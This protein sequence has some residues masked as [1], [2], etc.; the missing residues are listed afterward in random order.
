MII[1]VF[2]DNL[3]TQEM[4]EKAV[5]E[6]PWSLEYAHNNLKTQ[7]MSEKAVEG[8]PGT[9]KFVSDRFNT[10]FLCFKAVEA[11]QWQLDEVPDHLKHKKCVTARSG[12]VFLFAVCSL[13]GL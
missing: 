5:E 7:E 12:K 10:H 8:K 2:H 6:Y 13:I 1:G 3:K 11:V 4:C 9:L